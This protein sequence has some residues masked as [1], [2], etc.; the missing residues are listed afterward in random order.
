MT[1]CGFGEGCDLARSEVLQNWVRDCS[2]CD[3]CNNWHKQV[4]VSCL[5]SEVM[6]MFGGRFAESRAFVG[7]CFGTSSAT[8]DRKR[9]DTGV[10]AVT[11]GS[12]STDF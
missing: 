6:P 7:V 5:F 3:V 2:S 4:G 11:A 10:C 9:L 8:C 12:G 1:S